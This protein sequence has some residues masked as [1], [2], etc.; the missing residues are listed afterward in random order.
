[1]ARSCKRAA[2]D[3]EFQRALGRHE[4]CAQAQRDTVGAA[5]EAWPDEENAPNSLQ[6]LQ[7]SSTLGSLI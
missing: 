5:G 6:K 2:A 4:H 3:R 1:M 7:T